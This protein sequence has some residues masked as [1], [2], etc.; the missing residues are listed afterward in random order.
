M[1]KK[2]FYLKQ[3]TLSANGLM[4]IVTCYILVI[5]LIVDVTRHF[6]GGTLKLLRK[7]CQSK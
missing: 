5:H 7:A 1:K 3:I 2:F 6:S 4:F